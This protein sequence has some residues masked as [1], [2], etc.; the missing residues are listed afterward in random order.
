MTVDTSQL[1]RLLEPALQA[2]AHLFAEGHATSMRIFNGFY[3][4]CPQ[5]VADIYARTLLLYNYAD[6]PA[7]FQDAILT[8]QEYLLSSLPWLKTVIVKNRKAKKPS[9]R[10]GVITHGET[11]DR[12]IYEH[13]VWYALDLLM[14][15]DASFY[16]DTRDLR[17]WLKS[18]MAGRTVLNTFAY[19]GSLGIAAKA[20]GAHRVVFLDLNRKFLNL[21]KDSYSLNGFP[22]N[23]ADFQVGDFW[24]YTGKLRRDE[25]RYNCVIIDPPIFSTTKKGTIDLVHRSDRVINKVRPLV[26][27][28]GYLVI[29]NNALFVSGSEYI[30]RLNKLCSG[31]YLSIERLIPVPEDVTG[32]PDTVY[33]MP[34]AD[35]F[36]FN[37]PTKIVVLRVKHKET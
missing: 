7:N 28:N 23:K 29:I 20:G 18:S 10:N 21:A 6:P 15:Q 3:E 30:E 1:F 36:P 12:R 8:V 34:P 31:G 16:L 13:G 14:N 9:S 2:R 17:A 5:L 33:R 37:H 19:T 32:Y 26:T 4:G 22:I 25:E 27:N 24:T 11:P 35:P